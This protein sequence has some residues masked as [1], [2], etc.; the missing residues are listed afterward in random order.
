MVGD[1][2]ARLLVA[3]IGFLFV[4]AM[5]IGMVGDQADGLGTNVDS[6]GLDAAGFDGNGQ[7]TG[8]SLWNGFF[9]LLEVRVTLDLTQRINQT[10]RTAVYER[11]L[12]SPLRMYADQKIGDAV[13]RVM[14]D[15]ACIGAVLYRGVLAPLLSIVMFVLALIVLSLQFSNE[16]AIPIIAAL[17]LPAIGLANLFGRPLRERAQRT[18]ERGSDVMAAFE[19]RLAQV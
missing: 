8:W 19:E 10:V 14:S 18:R 7:N 6:G 9:G 2:R 17:I 16:P 12:R 1:D 5:L 3:V 4:A 15:S 13:F 11:L